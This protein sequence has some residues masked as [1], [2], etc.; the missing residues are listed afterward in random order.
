MSILIRTIRFLVFQISL[1][2]RSYLCA[3]SHDLFQVIHRASIRG[4]I[5]MSKDSLLK[6]MV[7]VPG[8]RVNGIGW[9]GGFAL[10][11]FPTHR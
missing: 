4:S 5:H 9:S 10:S 1:F 8:S 7:R 6:R 2:R 3:D 11:A